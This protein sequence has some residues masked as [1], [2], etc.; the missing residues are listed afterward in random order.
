MG[1]VSRPAPCTAAC[2]APFALYRIVLLPAF[3]ANTCDNLDL[4]SA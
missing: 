4:L 2:V 1:E 3:A